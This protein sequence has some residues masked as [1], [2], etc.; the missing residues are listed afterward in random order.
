MKFLALSISHKEKVDH[1]KGFDW[2]LTFVNFNPNEQVIVLTNTIMKIMSNFTRNETIL[3]NDK[4]P[5]WI[6]NKIKR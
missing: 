3:I 1:S 4:D 5:I 2:K 6:N